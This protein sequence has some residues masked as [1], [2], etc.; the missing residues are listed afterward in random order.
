MGSQFEPVELKEGKPPFDLKKVEYL[1]GSEPVSWRPAKGG[2]SV[3][4]RWVAKLQNGS[5]VFIK[6]ATDEDTKSWLKAEDKV[7]EN[8]KGDFMPQFIG[9]DEASSILA[10]EDLSKETWT[11]EWSAERVQAVLHMLEKVAATKTPDDFPLLELQAP[12]FNGWREIA[13]VPENRAG[14]LKLGLASSEWLDKALPILVQAEMAAKFEGD[15][16]VHV[17]VRSDNICFRGKKPMLVDWNWACRGNAKLDVVG[18]FPSLHVEG[19]PAPWDVTLDEPELI[20]ALA[21]FWAI[22]APRPSHKQGTAIRELQLK[23]LRS[24]LP[25]AVKALGLPPLE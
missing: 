20:T 11:Y 1:T 9:Y 15:S 13:A 14:F 4:E 25:W 6:A 5:S 21:G 23:Q 10:L 17:D 8:I 18:W 22:R 16:L 2:Y 12:K 19:G 24:A 3:A 7:Y